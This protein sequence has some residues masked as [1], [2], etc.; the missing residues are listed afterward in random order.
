[1][2]QRLPNRRLNV[3][4]SFR[5]PLEVGRRVRATAG[6]DPATG[7]IR[8]FFLRGGGRVSSGVDH[9]LNDI[10]V[11]VFPLLLHGETPAEVARGLG[12]LPTS[13]A[14][15]VDLLV[16]LDTERQR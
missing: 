1:M 12:R 15:A 13:V 9:L 14:V 6:F 4:S 7:R 16:R 3:T 11:L 8:E 10:A 5:W 2:R